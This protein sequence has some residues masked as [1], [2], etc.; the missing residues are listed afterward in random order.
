MRMPAEITNISGDSDGTALLGMTVPLCQI[1]PVMA[2]QTQISFRLAEG[3]GCLRIQRSSCGIL[4][5][6]FI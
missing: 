3:T 5:P 4:I 1:S 6:L 2:K